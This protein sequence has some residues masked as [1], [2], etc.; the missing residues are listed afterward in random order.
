MRHAGWILALLALGSCSQLVEYTD[1]LVDRRTGRTLVVRTPATLGGVVG[2]V[3]GVPLDIIALPVTY[4][5]YSFQ[6]D[7]EFV[8]ADPMSTMLFPSFVLWRVGTLVAVPFDAVEFIAYRAWLPPETPTAEEQETLEV[9]ED[10]E[11]FPVYPVERI[12]PPVG[13]PR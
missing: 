3:L 10:S 4:T 9:K 13:P 2:F 5:L 1:E 7:D 12:F 11:T 6:R 8:T